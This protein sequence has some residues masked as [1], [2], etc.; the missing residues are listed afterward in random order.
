MDD[1]ASF[2]TSANPAPATTSSPDPSGGAGGQPQAQTQTQTQPLASPQTNLLA[3]PP[4]ERSTERKPEPVTDPLA[5]FDRDG[6]Y[7]APPGAGRGPGQG[8]VPAPATDPQ[9][10]PQPPRGR[11]QA[12][13]EIWAE[14][15]AD[16]LAG[17]SAPA[18]CRRYGV[19]LT[20]LRDRAAREGWR[21]RDQPWVAPN[22]L[23][24]EDEGVQLEEEVDGD[25]DRVEPSHLAWVAHRRM[26]RA[27]MRGQATEALRWNRVEQ[28]MLKH[29]AELERLIQQDEFLRHHLKHHYENAD[30]TMPHGAAHPDDPDDP[31]ASDGI[32]PSDRGGHDRP[33]N[34]M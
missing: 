30:A 9:P 14:V 1:S 27:V 34:P 28:V 22:N 3:A 17:L 13:D 33:G 10:H 8:P 12:P 6:G 26:L 5:A 31:D 4:P 21:R 19:G 24:I 32:S 7:L 2:S 15:R 16:Y 18:C 29:E 20:A 25:L 11:H 23:D